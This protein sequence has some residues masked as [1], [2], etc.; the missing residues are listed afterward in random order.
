MFRGRP[1]P[2]FWFVLLVG[3]GEAFVLRWLSGA[4]GVGETPPSSPAPVSLAFWGLFLTLIGWIWQGAQVAGRITLQVLAWSVNALWAFA[5]SVANVGIAIGKAVIKAS[6]EVWSFLKLT[7]T[8]VLKPAWQKFWRFVEWAKRTLEHVL[9]PVFRFLDKVRNYVLRIYEDYVRPVL[10]IIDVTRRAL[11]VLA[12]L[13]IDWARALERRLAEL[14]DKIQLPFRLVLEK[15]NEVVNLVNRVVTADGLFQRLALVQS[16]GRDFQYA[17]RA[18]ANPMRH[19]VADAQ[20]KALENSPL[21][22]PIEGVIKDYRLYL[23]TQSGDEAS[24][25][26]DVVARTRPLLRPR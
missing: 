8:E 14:E 17:I 1:A 22:K 5:R 3:I 6:R 7:Y 4:H 26:R 21:G 2:P 15:I 24:M 13:G 11:R 19:P 18:L 23:S 10:D 16:L 9:K 12:A 20:R 25:I